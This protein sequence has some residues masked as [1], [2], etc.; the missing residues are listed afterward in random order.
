MSKGEYAPSTA[1]PFAPHQESAEAFHRLL[2]ACDSLNSPIFVHDG[3]FRLLFANSAYLTRANTSLDQVLGKPYWQV[4]PEVSGPLSSC[5]RALNS[6]IE[7]AEVEDVTTAAN[8]TFCSRSLAI[9]GAGG[10]YL[11]SVH[12]LEDVTELRRLEDAVRREKALADAAIACSPG[13][14]Y[15]IN[16]ER[17]Y[18]RWNAFV[19][20][21][22]G[23]SDEDIPKTSALRI[24]HPDDQPRVAAKIEEVFREGHA[25]TEARLV[26]VDR[27]VRDFTFTGRRFEV[28]GNVYLAG[29]GVDITDI[30]RARER[31]E[32]LATHDRLTGLPNR[33]L[34]FDRLQHSLDKAARRGEHSALLFVD[35]DNFKPI[36]DGLGHAMGDLLLMQVADRLRACTRKQDTVSRLG[37]DEFTVIAEDL[38]VS[39]DE[40]VGATAERI[41]EALAMPFDLGGHEASLSASIGIAFYPKDG[42]DVA[43]LMKSADTAMYRAKEVGKN[44]YQFYTEE[45]N[46]QAAARRSLE[47]DLIG[48]LGRGEFFLEFQPQM[49][50]GSGRIHGVE[51]LLRWRHPQRGLLLPDEFIPLAEAS[52]LIVPI[53]DWVLRAA[54]A[55][56]LEWAGKGIRGV[57]V[58]MNLSPRQFREEGLAERILAIMRESGVAAERLGFE[59]TETCVMDDAESA[60]EILRR[61]KEMGVGLAID[62]FGMGYSSLQYLKRFPID[63]LK[64]DGHFIRDLATDPEDQA[65]VS[66]I[67]TMGHSMH[68]EVIAE[69]VETQEQLEFLR[70][71]GCDR[72]QGYFIDHPLSGERAAEVIGRV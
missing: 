23:L 16:R 12:V 71:E 25:E 65:I 35:L 63:D 8:E 53:G 32:H 58:A 22:T 42:S 40:L 55:Q 24:V 64:I 49:G 3:E 14:F 18:V 48:A 26:T 44:N 6:G 59:I 66:A 9:H 60:T 69:G 36:N 5:L 4:F 33:N 28:D 68:L 67:I 29:V 2:H 10:T 46:A 54:C 21:L 13:V 30:K 41:I 39:S 51:A 61:L 52:G 31:M 37:G 72:V 62:D 50:L 34:F 11:Y 15:V 20:L 7:E 17:R 27:G 70:A 1:I 38:R 43:S 57:R 45:M 56:L 19:N 47:G